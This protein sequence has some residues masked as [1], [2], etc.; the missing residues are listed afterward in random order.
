MSYERMNL[1]KKQRDQHPVAGF[2]ENAVVS[3]MISNV[4]TK[5]S[6][7]SVKLYKRQKDHLAYCGDSFSVVN[8]E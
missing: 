4:G 2:R 3:A 7:P 6:L 5:L 1:Y 8:L